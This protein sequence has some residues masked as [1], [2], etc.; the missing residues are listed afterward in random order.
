MFVFS[1]TPT[2]PWWPAST[3]VVTSAGSS[4]R[5]SRSAHWC[6]ARE[7]DF[8]RVGRS[9]PDHRAAGD[10]A[11][12][13]IYP[14]ARNPFAYPELR[15]VEGLDAWAVKEVWMMGGVDGPTCTTST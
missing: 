15:I 4:A 8:T 11:L 7:R 13:A 2:A 9:H 12:D 1:A 14:D 5:Y 10:A 3:C 6:R